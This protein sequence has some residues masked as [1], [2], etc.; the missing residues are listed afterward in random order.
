M[1]AEIWPALIAANADGVPPTDLR[2]YLITRVFQPFRFERAPPGQT[3]DP[4]VRVVEP[5]VVPRR[6]LPG[7]NNVPATSTVCVILLLLANNRDIPFLLDCRATGPS[8]RS[9]C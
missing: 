5:I 7:P 8:L 4:E 6:F 9:G 3:T 2:S 1:A